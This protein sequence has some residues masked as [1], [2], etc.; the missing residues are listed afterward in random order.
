MYSDV[1]YL[2]QALISM[3]HYEMCLWYLVFQRTW[4]VLI[5]I[6]MKIKN[7]DG[8]Q[9]AFGNIRGRKKI[10]L[11]FR[12]TFRALDQVKPKEK[13][14]FVEMWHHMTG[15]LPLCLENLLKYTEVDFYLITE[16]ENMLLFYFFRLS[17]K[18]RELNPLIAHSG[19]REPP[20]LHRHSAYAAPPP[21]PP[22]LKNVCDD[23]TRPPSCTAAR[24]A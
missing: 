18:A 14:F 13:I 21:P 5:K 4:L 22:P 15:Y 3:T 10:T 16:S 9:M 11:I 12:Y 8:T 23:W 6:W 20:F 2:K 1:N 24:H 17:F 19:M 7:F